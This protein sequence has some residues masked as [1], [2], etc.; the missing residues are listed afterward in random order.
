MLFQGG[1]G[2]NAAIIDLNIRNL[3]KYL[4]NMTNLK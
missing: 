3:Y 4:S 2:G 1:G